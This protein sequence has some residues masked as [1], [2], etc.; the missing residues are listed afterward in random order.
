VVNQHRLRLG[1]GEVMQNTG[2]R[3]TGLLGR[4]GG[5]DAA[6][7]A[8]VVAVVTLM[9]VPLPTAVLDVLLAANLALS[10]SILLVSLYVPDALH[11]AS[12]PTLLLITTLSRV[13]LNVAA[14]RLILLR[15]D[16]GEVIRSFGR[17]VVGSN[18]VVGGVVFVVL[19]LVEYLVIAKGSERV[20]EVG[21]RFTLDALPGKQIGIDAELRTGAIDAEQAR[22]KR[23]QL[24]RESQFYGAMD[25][26]MKFVKGDV[27]ASIFIALVNILGGLAIGVWQRDM[28]VG[29]ALK[30][31][32]LLTIGNGL[33]TL[34]PA[35]IL[36]TSAGVLVTR[37]SSEEPNQSLAATLGAELFGQPRALMI[38]G[39]LVVGLGVVP[40]FPLVPF[41][42]IGIL[43]FL[44]SRARASHL[45]TRSRQA[46]PK[47][48]VRP[49]HAA[50][51][52]RFVPV[53]VPWSLQWGP[54]ENPV[55]ARHPEASPEDVLRDATDQLREQ[56]FMEL[57]VPLPA[58]HIEANAELPAASLRL[59]IHEASCS[60]LE[61]PQ[62][63]QI[64]SNAQTL[65]DSLKSVL[66]KRCAEF[67]GMSET[68]ALLTELERIAP[69]T[70]RQV[71][72]KPVTL[73]MLSEILRRLVEEG[74]SIRDLSAILEALSQAS[75]LDRD[76]LA[77]AEHVRAQLRRSTTHQLTAGASKLGVVLLDPSVEEV[78]RAA[79]TRTASGAFLALA[80]SATRDIVE[81]VRRAIDQA[82]AKQ[83]SI[84]VLLTSPDTRRFFR[85][86]V[87]TDL[88]DLRV[89]SPAE[90]L[91]E[92]A[93][94]A[95]AI[96][97]VANL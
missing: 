11:I 7:A 40:G 67:L 23:H 44:A 92:I 88:P 31:Y 39:L 83:A 43:L 17:V 60:N 59:M 28:A 52:L 47:P 77:L 35:L 79:I 27:I 5:S 18:Y 95:L 81:A 4:F 94:E 46:S 64:S 70:V 24:S 29:D 58:C 69:E 53:V 72:P 37:V 78:V 62:L 34:V 63:A 74:I 86:L 57:G 9:I 50:E 41:C 71:V 26:A 93:L 73:G 97:T 15:A 45:G 36:A 51:G 20:A 6:L 2:T 38:A 96:V 49:G 55:G 84:P 48:V 75:V 66:R 90:L 30:R 10:I 89:I 14:T 19:T 12:F 82:T 21:A 22:H 32:G 80:P 65:I 87:E 85:R 8:V 13:G 61:L 91:P 68:Q 1:F 56:L 76:P 33:V 25:G 3:A 42:S 16:A 54:L